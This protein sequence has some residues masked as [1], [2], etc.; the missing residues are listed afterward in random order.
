MIAH[1]NVDEN[2]PHNLTFL[3]QWYLRWTKY[4]SAM[5]QWKMEIGK[6][7]VFK[8]WEVPDQLLWNYCGYD[9][10]GTWQVRKKL[11]PL[12]K[13]EKTVGPFKN[14]M[15][16]N[17]PLMD[18]E[19]RGLQC[20]KDRLLYMSSQFKKESAKIVKRL[21]K[22]ADKALGEVRDPKGKIVLFNPN[23]HVQLAKLLKAVG[24]DLKKKTAGGGT[25]TDKYVLEAL[26]LKKNKA[27]TIAMEMKKLRKLESYITKNLDGTDGDGAF[28]Q[29][30]ESDKVCDRFHPTFNIHIARTGRQT[31]TDPPVQTMPRTGAIRTFIIPDTSDQVILSADYEKVELCVLSW[32]SNEVIMIEE[33]F[34]GIDLHTKMAVVARLMREPNEKEWERISL[35]IEKDE[36][37]VAKG[38]NFGIPYG[39]GAYAI[40]EESPD[41]FPLNMSM[42]D[43]T[44][45]VQRV[46]D[47]YFNKYQMI[48]EYR[49]KQIELVEKH[50]Q[51]RSALFN[52]KRRLPGIRWFN[53]KQGLMTRHRD[54]D[55]GHLHREVYNFQVQAIAGDVMTRATK[56]V[57]EGIKKVRI[58]GLRII[59]TLHDQLVF[60]CNKKY[61]DEASHHIIKW[62]ADKLPKTGPYK[63]EM[64]L[65]VECLEQACFGFEYLTDEEKKEYQEY[66]EMRKAA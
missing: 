53:S 1:A 11:I 39:R 54:K 45:K 33:L 26:S 6:K 2:K 43:R 12:L 55:L 24:A 40:A 60:T 15:G 59:L 20:D 41:S 56:R 57:Y 16:L 4:D 8:T 10:D 48:A 61:S 37:A 38:V 31:A 19:Y 46:I 22:K 58:P 63:H 44:N 18:A 35:L 28:I 50:G 30:L 9:C 7:K 52:R 27:G 14:H 25:A 29:Y 66:L 49:E 34:S 32:L 5:D 62:M 17:H 13:K 64:P 21:R 3:C 36:R 47:A 42:K 23:S 51:L 65:K